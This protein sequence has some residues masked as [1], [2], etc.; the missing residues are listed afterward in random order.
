[1]CLE[2][3]GC[4]PTFTS[5]A[6]APFGNESATVSTWYVMPS[7]RRSDRT[8]LARSSTLIMKSL[9]LDNSSFTGVL[10]CTLMSCCVSML[11][12]AFKTLI[13]CLR[14]KVVSDLG[15]RLFSDGVTLVAQSSN[16]GT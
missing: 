15:P 14:S 6:L 5:K 12:E 7:V 3:S 1:M 10:R 16:A 4:W 8:A 11:I 13:A 2:P 9:F